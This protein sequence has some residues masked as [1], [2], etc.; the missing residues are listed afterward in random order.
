[1]LRVDISALEDAGKEAARP[2]LGLL[3][4]VAAGAHGDE[5]GE[6][7]VLRPQAVGD[8]R[9]HAG[10]RHLRVAAVHQHERRLVV[11]D[12][13]LEGTDDAQVVG[14]LGDVCEQLTDLDA[15]PAVLLELEGAGQRATGLA[16]GLE[17]ERLRDRLAGVLVQGRLGVE[18]VDVAGA[19]VEEKVDDAL[20]PAGEMSGVRGERVDRV[21]GAGAWPRERAP[22]S[23]SIDASVTAPMPMPQR[24]SRSRRLSSRSAGSAR[25]W[26]M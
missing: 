18:R 5:A 13:R 23:P 12:L 6:V 9:A 17:A 1:M 22:R 3:D 16:L 20:G 7:L 26:S 10:P 2:V 19:A 25:W 24:R 15:A 21:V 14:A 11:G 8:P 4:R